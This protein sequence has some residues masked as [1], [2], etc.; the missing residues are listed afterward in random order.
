MFYVYVLK[1]E[2]NEFYTGYTADLEKRLEQH[3]TGINQSTKNHQW[4]LVYYEAYTN[5]RYAYK[6]EQALKKNRR[7]SKF[8]M[9]RIKESL[10]N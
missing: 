10:R 8:L 4:E 2:S 5:E 7:M 3:N 1:N 9:E 6:R